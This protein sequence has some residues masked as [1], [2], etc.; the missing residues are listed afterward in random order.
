[1]KRMLLTEI[2]L[3]SIVKSLNSKELLTLALLSGE[4][5]DTF[6][7]ANHTIKKPTTLNRADGK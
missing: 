2:D 3:A 7:T 4:K 1:M 5:A 6:N